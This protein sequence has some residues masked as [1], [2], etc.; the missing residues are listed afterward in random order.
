MNNWL[1]TLGVLL[2]L[3]GPGWA[4]LKISG[5]TQ[6][7]VGELVKLR[8]SGGDPQAGLAWMVYPRGKVCKADT[9][10][11]QL[12]FVAP[13]GVYTVDLLEITLTPEKKTRIKQISIQVT[14]GE[15]PAPPGP[16]PPVPPVPPV[17][18][19]D[20]ELAQLL[21][22]GFAKDTDP[23]RQT[24]AA[25]LGGLYRA[26]AGTTVSDTGLKTVGDLDG[27][28]RKA[29]QDQI[30]VL[31]IPNTRTA[32]GA[33]L[34]TQLPTKAATPLDDALRQKYRSAFTSLATALESLK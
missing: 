1:P 11:D 4:Q 16:N 26:A 3:A 28:V 15:P 5:P 10:E 27:V 8:A 33:W 31:A 34:R 32:A 13:A 25:K 20:A 7:A 19:P 23:D 17:P 30:G 9:A 14:F 24:A 12:Q 21:L 6:V 22:A 18:T 2:L 29:A